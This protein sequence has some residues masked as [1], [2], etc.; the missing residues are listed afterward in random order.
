MRTDLHRRSLLQHITWLLAAGTVW[1]PAVAQTAAAPVAT[2]SATPPPR[3]RLAA[4]WR[5]HGNT[6][7]CGRDC[8]QV[9][10]LE[11]DWTARSVRVAASLPVQ[12]RAHGLLA[13][14]DGG[15]LAVASRPGRWLLRCDVQGQLVARH[16]IDS[17]NPLR[18]LGGHVLAS[19][20]EQWLYTTETDTRDGSGWIGVRD[21]RTLQRVAQW[22]THGLDP[23]HLTLDASGALLVLNGG[24]PR[25]A[26]GQKTR[27]DAMDPSL[28]RL[29]PRSGAL[30]GQW[31]LDDPRLSLRHLA[32]GRA[33]AADDRGPARAPLLGIAL[34][35]EHDDAARRRDAPLL[36]LWDGQ[37]LRLANRSVAG[38]GYAGDIAPGPGGGF[39]VS[40]QR[41]HEGLLWHPD[42]PERWTPIA[43]LTEPCALAAWPDRGGVLMGAA[44]GI[45]FWH[46]ALP[47][48]MLAWPMAMAPDNH[49]IV[50]G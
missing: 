32:W 28:V 49:W 12:G 27:L 42:A 11:I 37:D 1:A 38:A 46:P 43:K 40:G 39:I 19:A 48:A 17:E 45:G 33:V 8:D 18:T 3:V 13:E 22:P 21:R 15:F 20:D 26:S 7:D 30:L 25:T 44:R 35:A 10:V 50:L 31:R 47:P 4:A 5:S 24:I 41:S 23:H 29:D 9:G 2:S 36:A 14:A 6:P 34:Q 16:L